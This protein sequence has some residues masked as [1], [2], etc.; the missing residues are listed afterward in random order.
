MHIEGPDTTREDQVLQR[1]VQRMAGVIVERPVGTMIDR[2]A[3]RECVGKV[4]GM[5]ALLMYL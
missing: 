1:R 5:K 2:K 3:D 4:D